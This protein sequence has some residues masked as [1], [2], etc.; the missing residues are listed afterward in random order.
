MDASHEKFRGLYMRTLN[1][2]L[3]ARGRKIDYVFVSH[4]EPDH[5]GEPALL[6]CPVG[7][8]CCGHRGACC[9]RSRHAPMPAARFLPARGE[10]GSVSPQ[11]AWRRHPHRPGWAPLHVPQSLVATMAGMSDG[12][13]HAQLEPLRLPPPLAGLVKDV[14]E[15]FPEAV[16]CGSKVCLQFLSNLI[17]TPFKSQAV[18]GGDKVGWGGQGPRAIG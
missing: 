13:G 14:V 3:A 10:A 7:L 6:A 12:S 5:S 4:T 15:Q 8:A 17:H 1:A 16:V 18:K 9:V 2:E 11:H